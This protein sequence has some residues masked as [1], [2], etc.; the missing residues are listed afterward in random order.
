LRIVHSV[1]IK[2]LQQ[3]ETEKTELAFFLRF[4][5]FLLLD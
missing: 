4:L 3:E 2:K 5:C 1:S